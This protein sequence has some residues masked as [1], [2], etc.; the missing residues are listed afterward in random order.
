MGSTETPHAHTM[1]PTNDDFNYH[2]NIF[3]PLWLY[4]W[5]PN[6]KV[7][8][9]SHGV[10]GP[11]SLMETKP[12]QSRG[13]SN[14]YQEFSEVERDPQLWPAQCPKEVATKQDFYMCGIETLSF[15]KRKRKSKQA[16]IGSWLGYWSL[17]TSAM[18]LHN[19]YMHPPPFLFKLHFLIMKLLQNHGKNIRT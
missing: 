3:P 1:R 15:P 6:Q 14:G 2:L 13:Q 5:K 12:C 7:T 18:G 16:S 17:V 19:N 10:T 8:V 11:Q 4:P 9:H